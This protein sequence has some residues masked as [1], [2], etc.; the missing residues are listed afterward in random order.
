MLGGG[1]ENALLHQAGGVADASYVTSTGFDREAFQVGAMKHNSGPRRCRQNPQAD[2][3]AAVEAHSCARDRSTNCLL[4][5]QRE[6]KCKSFVVCQLTAL[7][8]L[9]YVAK[10]PHSVVRATVATLT[11]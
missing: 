5:C 7:D 6:D 10:Q 11:Y 1:D 2:G 9:P 3:C 8:G 4:V